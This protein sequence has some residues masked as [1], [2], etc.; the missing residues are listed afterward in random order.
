[1]IS[2]SNSAEDPLSEKDGLLSS[3]ESLPQVGKMKYISVLFMSGVERRE[4]LTGGSV[5]HLWYWSVVVK[6]ELSQRAKL[7]IYQLIYIP[8]LPYGHELWVMTE[9][10]RLRIQMVEISFP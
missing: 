8:T 3:G 2:L 1:M 9:R 7:S 10:M 5:Q 6:R 4:R